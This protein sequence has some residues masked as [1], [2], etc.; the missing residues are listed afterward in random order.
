M[1]LKSFI[2]AQDK[3]TIFSARYRQTDRTKIANFADSR[4]AEINDL[5]HHVLAPQATQLGAS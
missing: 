5:G 2:G 3:Y 1:P 4:L